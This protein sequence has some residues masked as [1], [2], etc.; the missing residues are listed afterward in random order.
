MSESSRRAWAQQQK[1]AEKDEDD[2]DERL[3][4]MLGD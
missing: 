2:A 3:R 4:E 1:D